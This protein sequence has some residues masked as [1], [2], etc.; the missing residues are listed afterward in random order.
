MLGAAVASYFT[1][2]KEIHQRNQ[3][4]FHPIEEVA[5]LFIGIF[6]T[7]LPALDWLSANAAQLGINY[8]GG[9]YWITGGLSSMFWITRRPI[10]FSDSGARACRILMLNMAAMWPGIWQLAASMLWRFRPQ[11]SSSG[12]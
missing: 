2:R 7:M 6:L 3:F 4:T 11:R 12:R 5:Y 10:E 9:F 1:T 8:T